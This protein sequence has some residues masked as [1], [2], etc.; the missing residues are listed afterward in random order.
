MNEFSV[1]AVAAGILGIFGF[2]FPV[3]T[4]TIKPD[5]PE[6]PK[7]EIV[8]DLDD[9]F[10]AQSVLVFDVK[11]GERK[12][13]VGSKT[14]L[15]IASLTKIMTGL[16]AL[17]F[18][19]PD[20]Q[21][22]LSKEAAAT[23]GDVGH[24]RQGELFLV[25]DLF[26][27]MMMSSSN[28]AATALAQ[29]AGERMG[30]GTFDENIT[31]FVEAMNRKAGELGMRD[32]RFENPTGLDDISE[33]PSNYSSANDLATLIQYTQQV[34]LL[35]EL[36]RDAQ[37]DVYSD[38]GREYFLFNLNEI[39]GLIP[40]VVGSKTGSTP[41]AGDSLIFIFEN[42]LGHKQATILLGAEHGKR[43]EEAGRILQTV[44]SVLP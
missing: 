37:R 27:A 31:H 18:L 4:L 6:K 22:V 32:T 16:V 39:L 30:S 13:D 19:N 26:R 41:L 2:I 7:Y 10:T 35:W 3:Y 15:P 20:E 29:V 34:P 24:L 36:S 23:D 8:T 9:S 11:T 38:R 14:V 1:A 33:K 12:I 40:H 5:A 42:P 25:K 28:D 44:L 43:F 17:G 21:I